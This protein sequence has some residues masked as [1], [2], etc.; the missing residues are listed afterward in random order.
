[1]RSGTLTRTLAVGPHGDRDRASGHE[2][3][4]RLASMVD[5]TSVG[6]LLRSGFAFA[7]RARRRSRPPPGDA[8][9]EASG[10]KVAYELGD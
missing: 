1:M 6:S 8:F 9:Q 3:E 4:L 7:F 2:R 10:T 5:T